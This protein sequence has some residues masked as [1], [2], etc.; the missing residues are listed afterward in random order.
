MSQNSDD[1]LMTLALVEGQK[2]VGLTAPNP[3]V[4]AV[5]V[6]DGEVLGRGFHR[7]AG[8]AHAEVEAVAHARE[9]GHDPSGSDIFITL[10]PCSTTGRTP[11]CTE[12]L[13][14]NRIKRV[15]WAADDP[16]PAH[17]GVAREILTNQG[18]EV[19]SGVKQKEA[20]RLHCGFFK[21]QR[22]GLPWVIVKTAM[23]L[24]GRITRPPGE[25]QWLTG[26]EARNDVQILRGEVDAILTSGETARQDNPRLSYRGSRAE[27]K[28]PLRVVLSRNPWANLPESFHLRKAE[29][30]EPTL[31]LTGDLQSALQ[32]LAQRGVQTLLVEAGGTLIGDFLN[33]K[34]IDQ[35]IAYL[36][37]LATGGPLPAVAGEGVKALENH[38]CL[39]DVTYK[40]L[41]ND[42]RLQGYFH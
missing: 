5:L 20:E 10:E 16:N 6:R 38:L 39:Q 32:D 9:Q 33:Q 40:K 34:L 15:I 8:Q 24:D 13:I 37:P 14:K 26:P 36:A 19:V 22:E 31:F 42:I 18:I 21:V 4:G 30:Q 7:G 28:Q 27:K 23:S 11:P 35:W 29:D 3:S 17:Q 2:G 25:G 1:Y 41:G 12:L